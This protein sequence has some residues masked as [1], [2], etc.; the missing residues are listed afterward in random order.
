MTSAATIAETQIWSVGAWLRETVDGSVALWRNLNGRILLESRIWV[1]GM[2]AVFW[3]LILFGLVLLIRHGPRLAHD[4][5]HFFPKAIRGA[6]FLILGIVALV[7]APLLVG[8][9]LVLVSL[10]WLVCLWAY[11]NWSERI[12]AA[13]LSGVLF[14]APE[15]NRQIESAMSLPGS[16]QALIF[17]CS[18][19]LCTSDEEQRLSNM[20]MPDE[21]ISDQKVALGLIRKRIAFGRVSKPLVLHDAVRHVRAAKTADENSYE[22]TV[23]LANA[24]YV[25]ANQRCKKGSSQKKQWTKVEGLYR[26]A[27]SLKK[28]PIEALYN[29]SVLSTQMDEV[30]TASRLLEQAGSIDLGRVDSQRKVAGGPVARGC[31]AEFVGNHRLMDALPTVARLKAGLVKD[32]HAVGPVLLPYGTLLS[33]IVDVDFVRWSGLVVSIVLLLGGILAQLL[34]PAHRCRECDRLACAYCR[35]ELRALDLCETCLFVRVLGGFVDA[36]TKWLRARK[37]H[38]RQGRFSALSKATSLIIPGLGQWIRGHNFSGL[39]FM[40][41]FGVLFFAVFSAPQVVPDLGTE[42]SSTVLSIAAGVCGVIIYLVS[43]IHAFAAR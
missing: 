33:G 40:V 23:N 25:Q 17:E 14:F 18:H 5:S 21:W 7:V 6:P 2:L 31:P 30:V 29:L 13:I 12:V 41:G 4:L 19:D 10:T 28:R 37:Q 8:V 9:G 22:A 35:S 39:I 16:A 27:M 11:L 34:H 15:A 42:L 32:A 26:E 38:G 20:S 24:L 36:R 3:G 43:A 1:A